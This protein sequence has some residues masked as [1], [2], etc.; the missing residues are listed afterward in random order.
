MYKVSFIRCE[1]KILNGN[2]NEIQIKEGEARGSGKVLDQGRFCQEGGRCRGGQWRRSLGQ[3]P[4]WV[5]SMS[6]CG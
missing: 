5:I 3:R 2:N 1:I 4:S 6:L